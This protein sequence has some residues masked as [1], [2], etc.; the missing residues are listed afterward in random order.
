MSADATKHC[1]RINTHTNITLSV[2]H[3]VFMEKYEI[4]S[5][6]Q[7]SIAQNELN[8]NAFG[9]RL[10][11]SPNAIGTQ[12]VSNAFQTRSERDICAQVYLASLIFD[13]SR[14]SNILNLSRDHIYRCW[15]GDSRDFKI[16]NGKPRRR[17]SFK[18]NNSSYKTKRINNL[19]PRVILTASS[20]Y[21]SHFGIAQEAW[22]QRR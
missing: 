7:N 4:P 1:G 9:T 13:F 11:L 20:F 12:R 14:W 18:Q 19:V 10:D 22:E 5:V 3:P 16:Y 2:P 21:I 15:I 17:A 6:L 8:E